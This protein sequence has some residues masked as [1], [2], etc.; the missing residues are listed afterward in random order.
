MAGPAP[1]GADRRTLLRRAALGGGALLGAAALPPALGLWEARAQEADEERDED[2]QILKGLVRLE[3]TAAVTYEAALRTGLLD[4]RMRATARTLQGQEREHAG[5][6][7]ELLEE[8]GE[9]PP[10]P[11]ALGDIKGLRGAEAQLDVVE[12]A[13]QL[14]LMSVG[15]YYDAARRGSNPELL[16]LAASIMG[17][18]GRHLVVLRRAAG[19]DPIPNPFETGGS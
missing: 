2:V 12:Y 5:A 6:L 14:E 13:I 19:R 3:Q 16:R 9:D 17:S 18:E 8:A 10:R 1:S 11:P 4:P 7:R 15:A